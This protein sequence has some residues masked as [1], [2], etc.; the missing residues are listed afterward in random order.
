MDEKLLK[1]R[2]ALRAEVK[3]LR[4]ILVEVVNSNAALNSDLSETAFRRRKA[5][6][7]QAELA[8]LNAEEE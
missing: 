6:M 1:E 5:A 2:D 8:A 3:R 4:A 7:E